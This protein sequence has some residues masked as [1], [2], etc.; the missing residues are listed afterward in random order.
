[1]Y[2]EAAM[3]ELVLASN[4]PTAENAPNGPGSIELTATSAVILSRRTSGSLCLG[5]ILTGGT[6]SQLAGLYRTT[7]CC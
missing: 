3:G 2:L 6:A 4:N 5:R 7:A 1:M